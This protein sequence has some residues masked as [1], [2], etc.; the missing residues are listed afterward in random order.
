MTY[1]QL[2]Q[3][4]KDWTANAETTFTGEL[5]FIIELAES[6][7]LRDSDLNGTRKT[8]TATLSA[9]DSFLSKPTD[10]VVIR[11]LQTVGS[12][13]DRVYLLHKDKSFMDDFITDR[14]TTGSPRYYS[15]WDHDTLYVVPAP[16][17]DTTVELSYTYKP[18]GLSTTTA[19]TWLGDNAPDTLLYACL[20]ESSLFMKEAPD[21]T[22]SYTA[23][24]Q[25][26]MQRLLLEENV[27]NRTDEYRTR[28]ITL[29][30]T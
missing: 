22:Q 30:E 10:A 26:A 1:T 24:Y 25:E 2:V 6:R 3:S 12:S 4:I 23:K 14:T 5:D 21:L 28:S 11:G 29:G 17:V 20:I 16:A 7:I 9:S 19:T 13:G 15:H 18:V 8:V 27:R